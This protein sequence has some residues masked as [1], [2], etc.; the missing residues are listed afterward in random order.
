VE[1][2]EPNNRGFRPERKVHVR[3][4]RDSCRQEWETKYHMTERRKISM[5]ERRELVEKVGLVVGEVQTVFPTAEITYISM[6]PRF[7]EVCCKEHMTED[8]VV[9]V[10][11]IRREVD[12][13]VEELLQEV[14]GTIRI[15]HWWELGEGKG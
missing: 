8:D 7:V 3:R 9:V 2:G 11:S 14:D 10:E 15:A 13:E 4:T 6:F 12:K 1:H 5:F